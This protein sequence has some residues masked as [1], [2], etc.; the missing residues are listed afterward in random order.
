MSEGDEVGTKGADNSRPLEESARAAARTFFGDGPPPEFVAHGDTRVYRVRREADFV[1][2]LHVPLVEG[3]EG[4]RR[5]DAAIE[6]ECMW[7]D[8]L[9]EDL[10]LIVP[11]PVA[12]KHGGGFVERIDRRN[13]DPVACT[14]LGWI[15]GEPIEGPRDDGFG[16]E[17]GAQIAA[18]H[19]HACS[20]TMPPGF[21]ASVLD[22]TAWPALPAHFDALVQVGALSGDDV[23]R[24]AAF[25]AATER[26]PR[27][28]ADEIVGLIHG[29]LHDGNLLRTDAGMAILDFGRAGVGSFRY[30]LAQALQMLSPAV[31]QSCVD[32]YAEVFPLETD[33]VRVLEEHFVGSFIETLAHH[34]P[35]PDE[36]EYLAQAVPLARQFADLYLADRPFLFGVK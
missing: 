23:D 33:D 36:V 29:D 13:G 10:D 12:A 17:L 24:L 2:R 15:E 26:E 25:M 8:A 28:P 5:S 19:G 27:M 7:L 22:R 6:S 32:A 16:R 9:S 21:E 1:L 14:A 34:A 20:W 18:L 31:R 35:N 11:R 4:P 3:A 30:D